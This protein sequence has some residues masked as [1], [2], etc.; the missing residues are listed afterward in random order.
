MSGHGHD[1]HF[2]RRSRGLVGGGSHRL[3]GVERRHEE[4]SG[5]ILKEAEVQAEALKK[6]KILQAK[7]KFLQMKEEH[8]KEVRERERTVHQLHRKRPSNANSS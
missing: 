3:R 1:E 8:E 6:E 7:E 2:D 5:G 4:T